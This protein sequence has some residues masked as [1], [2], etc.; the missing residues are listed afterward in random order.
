MNENLR[1]RLVVMGTLIRGSG[2][3]RE[4]TSVQNAWRANTN[5][6][7]ACTFNPNILRKWKKFQKLVNTNYRKFN[8]LSGY[9]KQNTVR[10]LV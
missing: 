10:S 1:H 2:E 4:N 5:I 6:K 8:W 3:R 9:A 7:N